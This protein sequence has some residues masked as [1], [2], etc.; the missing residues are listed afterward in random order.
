MTLKKIVAVLALSAVALFG[1]DYKEG[2]NYKTLETPLPG[3]EKGTIVKVWSFT[4]PFCYKYDKG[5]TEKVITSIPGINFEVWHLKT[6]GTYGQQG[7]NLMAVAQARDI[8]AGI[9]NPLDKNGLL[10]K[11]KF[12]YYKAYHNKKERWD[13]GE[14]AFYAEGFKI[15][16][17][18]KAAFEKELAT[19]EVQALLKRWDPAY[20]VAKVQGIPGFVVD[21]KYLLY[22]QKIQSREYMIDLIKHLMAK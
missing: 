7:S 19:P 4:C 11:M 6:K 18:D 8:A 3:V 2:V 16:G 1:A 10:K 12:T 5:V 20:P 21:G 17:V 9:K 14:D 22:T 13:A 15:L